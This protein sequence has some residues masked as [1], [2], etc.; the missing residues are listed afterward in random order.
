MS[1]TRQFCTLGE[2]RL[3]DVSPYAFIAGETRAST[4]RWLVCLT[5]WSVWRLVSL[6]GS[7][8]GGPGEMQAR[9][10]TSSTFRKELLAFH[11]GV[12]DLSLRGCHWSRFPRSPLS[13][14]VCCVLLFTAEITSTRTGCSWCTAP[15]TWRALPSRRSRSTSRCSIPCIQRS[16]SAS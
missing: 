5:L 7:S 11:A 3:A 2:H 8:I 9:M 13:P 14:R 10:F 6:P 4:R 15:T 16:R 1:S 12:V